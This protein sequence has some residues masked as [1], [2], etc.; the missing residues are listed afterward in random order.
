MAE[1]TFERRSDSAV[2]RLLVADLRLTVIGRTRPSCDVHDIAASGRSSG[3]NG[4]SMPW[5]LGETGVTGTSDVIFC[6]LATLP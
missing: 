3:E 1:L 5:G 4:R 2:Q 6:K